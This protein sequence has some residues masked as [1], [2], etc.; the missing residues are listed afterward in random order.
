MTAVRTAMTVSV[1]G[2]VAGPD[3]GQEYPL[4]I[5][6]TRLFEWYSDG[7]TPGRLPA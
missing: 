7:D 3:D 5:G 2:Y 6:G 4:G 1:D